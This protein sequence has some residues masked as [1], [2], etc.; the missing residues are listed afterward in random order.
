VL[1]VAVGRVVLARSP[2][3]FVRHQAG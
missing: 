1:I 2:R 3:G